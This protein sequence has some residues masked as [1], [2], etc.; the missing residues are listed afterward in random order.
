MY[1]EVFQSDTGHRLPYVLKRLGR[2][3]EHVDFTIVV[4]PS[5]LATSVQLKNKL[6][7]IPLRSS[8][9]HVDPIQHNRHTLQQHESPP[10]RQDRAK[11]HPRSSSS[12]YLRGERPRPGLW[13]WLPLIHSARMGRQSVVSVDISSAMVDGASQA[14]EAA[15]A[16]DR[17]NFWLV[18]VQDQSPSKVGRSI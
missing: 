4:R 6:P 8:S 12:P 5:T 10:R 9:H 2:R 16:S 14:A 13:N 18:I 1:L 7:S 3:H 11:Q 15:G 17:S